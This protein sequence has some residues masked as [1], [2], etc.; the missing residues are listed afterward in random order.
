MIGLLAA[1]WS[2]SQ[3]LS[4]FTTHEG[5]IRLCIGAMALGLFIL[6]KK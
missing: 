2:W 6:L 3:F 1:S 5:V 4:Y